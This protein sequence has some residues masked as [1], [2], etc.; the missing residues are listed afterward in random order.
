M[1]IC[2]Q[3]VNIQ[4][5]LTVEDPRQIVQEECERDESWDL[6]HL[7]QLILQEVLPRGM[8]M[9]LIGVK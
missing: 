8:K 9:G 7:H 2:C 6:L 5:L 3:H 4:S 1:M